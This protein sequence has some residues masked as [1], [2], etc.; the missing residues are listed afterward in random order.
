[1]SEYGDVRPPNELRVTE[2]SFPGDG[3]TL[4]DAIEDAYEKG[5]RAGH[6]VLRVRDIYVYGDNPISGYRV[7]VTP[8]P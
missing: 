8:G 3:G 4:G 2:E 5:K 6:K 7:V 1:M